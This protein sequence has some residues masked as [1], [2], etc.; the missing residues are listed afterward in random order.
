MSKIWRFTL[1]ADIGGSPAETADFGWH[2]QTDVGA[3]GSEPSAETMLD[4]ILSHLSSSGHNL[5]SLVACLP[6]SATFAQARVYER[7]TPGSGDPPGVAVE[8]LSI[9]GSQSLGSDRLPNGIATYIGLKTGTAGRS[10]RGGTHWPGSFNPADLSAVGLWDAGSTF[11]I[12][13]VTVGNKIIDVINDIDSTGTDL[14][15]VIYSL[16][17]HQ[18]GLDPTTQITSYQLNLRPRW[19]SRRMNG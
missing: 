17:R 1:E 15:P 3:L 11:R 18:R 9:A 12:N 5:S 16:V 14:V 4:K 8:A 7:V 13:L 10:F 19:V 6:T 2:Y